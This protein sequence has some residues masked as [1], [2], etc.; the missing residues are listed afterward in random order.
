MDSPLPSASA[1]AIVLTHASVQRLARQSAAC[2]ITSSVL[3][4]AAMLF[5]SGRTGGEGLLWAAAPIG[6]LALTDAGYAAKARSLV[7]MAGQYGAAKS[8]KWSD[9]LHHEAASGG[10]K[11]AIQTLAAI[12]SLTIWPF[13][14][15]LALLVGGLGSLQSTKVPMNLIPQPYPTAPATMQPYAGGP[16]GGFPQQH[17]VSAPYGAAAQPPSPGAPV[18]GMN[19]TSRFPG[20]NPSAPGSNNLQRPGSAPVQAPSPLNRTPLPA[21]ALPSSAN[22]G[23][24]PP[25]NIP[26]AGTPVPRSSVPAP[27]PQ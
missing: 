14:L 17:P 18:P 6:L 1:S 21:P 20:T 22:G 2:K 26:A 5:A 10:L 3:S 16:N 11:G 24:A 9:L 23:M 13:Y 12:A 19:R 15:S 7:E 25:L 8:P 27:A 4:G